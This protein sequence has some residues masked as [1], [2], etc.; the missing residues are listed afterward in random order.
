MVDTA[1][2]LPSLGL[3]RGF[4]A[5]ARHL[6]FTRAADELFITQSAVSR[7]IKA[8][9][10]R[11]G[12]SL[13]L[14]QP[15]GLRLTQQG[16]RLYRAVASALRQ[17]SDAMEGLSQRSGPSVVTVTSTMGFCALWLVPRLGSFQK[18]YPEVEV[19]IAASD[20]VLNLDRERIDV[21]IRYCPPHAAPK[22]AAWLFDEE[23]LP[24]CSP[25]LLD[26]AG[27]QLKEPSD[28]R[29]HVLL[30]LDDQNNPSPWLSWSNWLEA[31]GV[32][33]LKPAG[34][35]AFNYYD[36]VVRAA[37]AGQGIALGRSP[38]VH[39]L[40]HDGS[41]VVPLL[42]RAGTDR[43]YW[44]V[45]AAFAR[46][47]PEVGQF[48]QWIEAEAQGRPLPP[49]GAELVQT[50]GRAPREAR[51]RKQAAPVTSGNA[52]RKRSERKAR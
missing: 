31:A 35:L 17:V 1:H 25:A 27:Q 21:S 52:R 12:V 32:P 45:Q 13:F 36:Q 15:K 44:V 47:R 43:G 19:R 40:L 24:V 16:E 10:D 23:L 7:Q 26:V 34:S 50:A 11:L 41:L 20:R 3:L 28:L 39:D 14:R 49:A 33:G 18:S 30:H 37:L 42:A 46:G 9:E 51:R 8:L 6:N 4:E 22:G 48:V 38:L 5:A 29:H 2:P